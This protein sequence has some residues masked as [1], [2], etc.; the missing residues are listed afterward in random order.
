MAEKKNDSSIVA[1]DANSEAKGEVYNADDL[2][3][4]QMGL[5]CLFARVDMQLTSSA[6]DT[7]KSSPGISVC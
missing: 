6:K 5:L 2:R 4:Q 3:L 7:P 1:L